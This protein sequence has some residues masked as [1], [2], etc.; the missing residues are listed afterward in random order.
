LIGNSRE[1]CEAFQ[2]LAALEV[3]LQIDWGEDL[4]VRLDKSL[5][6][7]LADDVA[8]SAKRHSFEEV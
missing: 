2:M 5:E 3:H 7:L 8:V 6:S 4:F 1:N